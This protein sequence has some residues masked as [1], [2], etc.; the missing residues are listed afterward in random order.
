VYFQ[1]ATGTGDFYTA[2]GTTQAGQ[3]PATTPAKWAVVA[4]PYIFRAYLMQGG[5]AD[6]LTSDGQTEKAAGVEPAASELLELEADKLQR[7][8]QQTDRL[9][10]LS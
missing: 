2:T 3:S 9:T 6:W 8:Q 7:Q 10:W 5:Y 1:D 4:L